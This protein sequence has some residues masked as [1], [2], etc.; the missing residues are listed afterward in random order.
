MR[1]TV[2]HSLLQAAWPQIPFPVQSG[3]QSSRQLHKTTYKSQTIPHIPPT[4]S[5][6]ESKTI[7][8]STVCIEYVTTQY[9]EN[10]LPTTECYDTKNTQFLLCD[11]GHF[12]NK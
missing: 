10:I 1:E 3:M 8:V 9:L 4:Q 11:T 12:C 2:E 5:A 7:S 6:L